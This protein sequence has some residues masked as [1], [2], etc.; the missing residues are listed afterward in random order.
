[1]ANILGKFIDRIGEGALNG[2]ER[3]YKVAA[4]RALVLKEQ[5][6]AGKDLLA[7]KK[8]AE[9]DK[10]K[11]MEDKLTKIR[12]A[13]STQITEVEEEEQELEREELKT[14][15]G[16]RL[17][18]I[19]SDLF[20]GYTK[21]P[22]SFFSNIQEDLYKANIMMPVSKYIALAMG[23]SVI[24]AIVM[25]LVLGLGIS[26]V[27]GAV[28][29]LIGLAL[30]GLIGI[31]I[32][33]F[34]KIYPSTIVKG[35]SGAF[36]KELPVAL[37]HMATQLSSG[38]GLLETMRSV[39]NSEYGVLSE[40]FQRA[41]LEVERGATIEEAYERMNLRVES[42]GLKKATRQIISTLSTG[43]NLANTLKLIAEEV[44]ME[45]R[46]KLKDFIQLLNTV[47]MMFM[48]VVVVAPV[49]I[50][51]LVIAMGIAM[52]SLP[53]PG[54][55]MWILYFA[56]FGAGLYMSVMVKKMEPSA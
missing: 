4:Q 1:M 8:L 22:S 56:F 30:G 42:E 34:S 50:T 23:I 40:E 15:F 33:V 27:I 13:V 54:D 49:L 48:F 7:R 37:R 32:F 5:D 2:A 36:S 6:A 19:I 44:S 20:S 45:M 24:S 29:W 41:I 12:D 10:Q 3:A 18:D 52:K 47:G 55:I 21:A 26:T 28:G 46:M 17:A 14:P 9:Q 38:S 16:E 31:F 35:R 43:G 39:S 11:E 25:G 51:T 53:I